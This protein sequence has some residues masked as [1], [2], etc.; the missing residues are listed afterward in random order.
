MTKNLMPRNSRR[1]PDPRRPLLTQRTL[2]IVIAAIGAGA[3][4]AASPTTAVAL[5]VGVAV[6]ALLHNVTGE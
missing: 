3:V 4:A 6:L 1:D 2:L 5:T